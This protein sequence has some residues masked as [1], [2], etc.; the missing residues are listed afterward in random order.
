M[1]QHHFD[2]CGKNDWVKK[3]SKSIEC[4]YCNK[5]GGSAGMRRHHFD[6][7]KQNPNI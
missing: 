4:P 2:N 5:T 7:C 3:R 6:N 1:K